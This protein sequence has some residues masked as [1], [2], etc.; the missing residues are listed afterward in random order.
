VENVA[1]AIALAA[2]SPKARGRAYT[3]VDVHARQ[4][5]YARFYR[6]VTGASWRPVY[7]PLRLVRLAATVVERGF[8]LAGRRAPITRHQVERTVRSATFVTRR[9]QDELGWQPRV[10]VTEALRRTLAP[11]EGPPPA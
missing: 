5:D 2:A 1:D 8:R 6:R 7:P 11:D 3:I 9:A 4:A 10:P